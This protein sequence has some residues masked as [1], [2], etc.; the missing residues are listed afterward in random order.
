MSRGMRMIAEDE[1]V[2]IN[3][4]LDLKEKLGLSD[5]EFCGAPGMA[6]AVWW[7]MRRYPDDLDKP[8]LDPLLAILVRWYDR[9]PEDCPVKPAPTPA[10]I[11]AQLRDAGIGL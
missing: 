2:S 10:D 7:T 4:M 6:R 3:D 11:V 9:H 5:G 1:P 8:L